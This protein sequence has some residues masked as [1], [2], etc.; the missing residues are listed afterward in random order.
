MEELD[1]LAQQQDE[2]RRMLAGLD[3]DGFR[4]PSRCEGWTV[5]DVALHVAQTNEMAE[6]SLNGTFAD[7][8]TEVGRTVG[9]AADVDDGAARMVERERYVPGTVV[10]E[11][12]DTGAARLLT[13]FAEADPHARVPWVAGDLA[14]RTLATTRLAETW[15]HTGDIADASGVP[16]AFED[17]HRLV[18]RLAWRTIPYAFA[19]AGLTLHGPVAFHLRGPGG[20]AWRFD[21]DEPAVTT[22][23]GDAR[24]LCDVAARRVDPADTT[25]TGDGPDVD[26]VLALVRT[27]A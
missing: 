6:A 3:E 18:A 20:D 4:R 26:D 19:R 15:I 12:Y 16:A 17:R 13:L 7:Y 22:I 2:M 5:A 14:V 11:R 21:P 1:A 8:M 10:R 24:E 9:G 25:L 23:T 27:Y